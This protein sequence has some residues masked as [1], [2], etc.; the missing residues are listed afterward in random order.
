VCFLTRSGTQVD[1]DE[2]SYVMYLISTMSCAQAT[3]FVHP[4]LFQVFPLDEPV[5][6]GGTP[7]PLPLT[8]QSVQSSGAYILDDNV[9]LRLFLG[10]DIPTAFL[11]AVFG[12]PSPLE[13]VDPAT[14]RVLPPES[15]ALAAQLHA[16]VDALRLQ[17][18]WAWMPLRVIRQGS[19]DGDF[20]RALIEDQTRQIMSYD[21][22]LV[23]CH[24]HIL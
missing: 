6:L 10:K 18:P 14:L 24:R 4:R 2:R 21:E 22:F 9:V 3:R 11:Q 8:Q 19:C 17:T 15:S 12:W 7:V 20:S 13:G 23:H 1:S 16:I 5:A